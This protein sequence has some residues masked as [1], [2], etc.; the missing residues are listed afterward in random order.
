M[1]ALFNADI[2]EAQCVIVGVRGAVSRAD[3]KLVFQAGQETAGYL[4]I[5]RY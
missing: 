1:L 3:R 5:S 4:C 2:W